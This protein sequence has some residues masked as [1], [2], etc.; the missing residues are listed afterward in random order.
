MTGLL[1]QVYNSYKFLDTYLRRNKLNE[2]F[3]D[4]TVFDNRNSYGRF[5]LKTCFVKNSDYKTSA[6]EWR[7]DDKQ[8]IWWDGVK[9]LSA[10]YQKSLYGVYNNGNTNGLI[11]IVNEEGEADGEF[12]E[13][14]NTYKI[15]DLISSD[16]GFYFKSALLDSANEERGTHQ[17]LYFNAVD[18]SCDNL[19]DRVAQNTELEVV[20][21]SVGGD[22]LYYCAARGLTV[23]NGKI[24]VKT[25]DVTTLNSSR[26]LSQ[27]L[28]VK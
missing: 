9:K 10:S 2:Y 27:I 7:S 24:N 12:V 4:Q 13:A 5:L 21:F 8:T 6:Y 15:S 17:I 28:T 19:F 1:L 25:K 22:Y 11:K 16:E 23:I 26:K 18:S 14:L 20:S 3:C